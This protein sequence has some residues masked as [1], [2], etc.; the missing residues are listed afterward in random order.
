M[1][2]KMYVMT[3]KKYTEVEKEIYHSLQVGRALHDDLGYEN[4]Y[5]GD[6]I[7]AKNNSFCELTGLYY[8]WKNVKCDVIGICHYRRFFVHNEDYIGKEKIENVLSDYDLIVPQSLMM[9]YENV[10]EHY[11]DYHVAKDWWIVREIIEKMRPECIEAFDLMGKTKMVQ[12]YNMMIT[13]KEIFDEYCSWL[14]PILFE[15]ER[16]V[17]IS[18][19]DSY[20]GRIFGFVSERLFKVWLLCKEYKVF[21]MEVRLIDTENSYNYKKENALK[22]QCLK[23]LLKDMTEKYAAGNPYDIVDNSAFEIDFGGKMPIWMCW[24]QGLENAPAIV[25][26]CIESIDKNV[27]ADRATIYLVTMENIGELIT[28]PSWILQKYSEGKITLTHLSDIVRMGLLYRYG[29]VWIDATYYATSEFEDYFYESDGYYSIKTGINLYRED[30]T[31]G[32]WSG[33]FIK[34]PKGNILFRYILNAFYEYWRQF[35]ELF[36]YYL[37]DFLIRIAYDNIPAITNMVDEC[38]YTQPD[39]FKLLQLINKRYNRSEY[40]RI[41]KNTN[42]FK[43]SHKAEMREQVLTGEKTY[44][45]QVI[46]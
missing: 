6:N 14:F 21:E 10:E 20:Q 11:L 4:D 26:K 33:N 18:G 5:E 15:M 43:L 28:L 30:I 2:T 36:D 25:Q 13:R 3:H 32:L 19:Y 29:G 39:V 17:D 35:D 31:A 45:G 40:E 42:V 22:F 12:P 23:A 27:D 16:I 8:L 24:F 37:I 34:G 7:S 41:T 38:P 9:S 1:D 46:L 44:Y